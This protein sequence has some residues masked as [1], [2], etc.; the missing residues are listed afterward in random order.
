MIDVV[1]SV[2]A[3]NQGR[4][5]DRLPMKFARM[6]ASAFGFLRG[7][8]H[9]FYDRLPHAGPFA[10][11]AAPHAW[12]CGDAHLENFGSY[13]GDNR[14]A[15]FD[16]NDFDEATLAPVTWDLV[17]FLASVLVADAAVKAT[18]EQAGQLCE[19]FL[20]AYAA[21]LAGGKAGWVERD[22]T[23]GLVRS[24]LDDVSNR[25]R[26]EFLD[27]RTVL[28]GKHRTIRC[29]GKHA[30]AASKKQR[31]AVE[32]LISGVA[33]Q[34]PDPAFYDVL[35]VAR[36]IAGT[37]S[38][39]V[40]RFIVLVRGKG[41]PDNNYLLDL[42]QAMPSA[43]QQHLT[44]RQPAWHSE[45][46][47][48]VALQRRMQ[49]VSMAFLQPIDWQ[50]CSY[51]LRGLLPSEDRVSL[52]APAAGFSGIRGAIRTMA[53]AMA[54]AHLRSSGREGSAIADEFIAF[55]AAIDAWR[56][57]MLAAAKDVARQVKADF[58]VFASA[59][60]AGRLAG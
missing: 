17:R 18:P 48:V 56:A 15:Y 29:D 12:I 8:A 30:L 19:E 9:L 21:V 55:G 26:P 41:S 23:D 37:G 38:L 45:A 42:K 13:K 2:V 11:D 54:S 53:G 1:K 4:D 57:P 47:R 58:E 40:D 16:I 36:R 31:A 14:L 25:T 39:G 32:A 34:A 3:F 46:A 43:P 51:I 24:L 5:P 33:R 20:D 35:D 60:D 49:A 27:R 59:Y 6:R 28:E 22:T 10:N 52:C 7:S 50:G 44:I